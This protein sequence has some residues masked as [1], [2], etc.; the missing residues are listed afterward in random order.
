VRQQ[1]KVTGVLDE[2]S[3]PELTA[4]EKFVR[5]LLKSEL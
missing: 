2:M 5:G 4:A 3:Q 1:I